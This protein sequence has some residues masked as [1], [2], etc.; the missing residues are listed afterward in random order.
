M[1]ARQLS[2]ACAAAG[3]SIHRNVLANLESGR[4]PYI[5]AAE[6][7]VIARVLEIPPVLLLF[8]LG[9]EESI[10]VV[11]G[12]E[13]DPWQA[14]KWF[15]GEDDWLP[16]TPTGS[17]ETQGSEPVRLFREHDQFVDDWWVQRRR[18][19]QIA[20]TRHES[21]RRFRTEAN[22]DAVDEQ[23]LELVARN[24]R[25]IEEALRTTRQDMRALGLNPPPLGP[26]SAFIED[27][28]SPLLL[29]QQAEREGRLAL[30]SEARPPQPAGDGSESATTEDEGEE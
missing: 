21:L 26:E 10:E 28:P 20:S 3:A 13:V 4:R 23:M 12:E 2:D 30:L 18:L 29:A 22:P 8:P 1:S 19:E 24:M 7:M 16:N 5:S 11:P 17:E 14:L 9:L 15:T 27:P 25:G 6:L